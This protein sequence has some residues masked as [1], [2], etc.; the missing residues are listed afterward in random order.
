MFKNF[1]ERKKNYYRP[2]PAEFELINYRFVVND[3]NIIYCASLLGNN[4]G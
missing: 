1:L 2:G 4:F 3:L